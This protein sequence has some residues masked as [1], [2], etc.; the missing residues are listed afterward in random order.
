MVAREI[1]T[2]GVLGAG[3]CQPEV[4]PEAGA[5]RIKTLISLLSLI[6]LGLV[7]DQRLPETKG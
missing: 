7:I 4:T 2:D 5:K 6:L 3:Y 1:D